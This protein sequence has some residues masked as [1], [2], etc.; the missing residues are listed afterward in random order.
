MTYNLLDE[1]VNPAVG[2][3]EDRF[4]LRMPYIELV[5]ENEAEL[6]KIE[7][8]FLKPQEI[9]HE[10]AGLFEFIQED[11]QETGEFGE[12]YNTENE[13]KDLT[14]SIYLIPAEKKIELAI[15]YAEE[16]SVY[17]YPLYVAEY[18]ANALEGKVLEEMI[19]GSSALFHDE[20]MKLAEKYKS[21][22]DL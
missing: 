9:F 19:E 11:L 18:D 3:E 5:G 13:E 7:I 2:F 14:Y 22:L 1:E 12:E 10:F 20:L 21:I 8:H 6:V 16:V 15:N 17:E 4:V